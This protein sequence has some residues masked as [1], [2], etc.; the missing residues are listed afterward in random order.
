[1]RG[2]SERTILSQPSWVLTSDCV[3]MAVTHLGAH[4]APVR[5]ACETEQPL[6]PYYISPWQG[7]NFQLEGAWSEV[8]LR[9]DFFCMPFGTDRDSARTERHPSHGETSGALWSLFRAAE[10]CG[11]Q[12]LAIGLTTEARTGKVKRIFSLVDGE[13][14]IY[15]C[16]TIWGFAGPT[17]IAHHAVLRSPE[18]ERG[19]LLSNN[20]IQFA[21]VYPQAFGD[22]A[23]GEY[24]SLEIGAEFRTLERVPSIF[25]HLGKQDC[26]SWPARRGFSD[27]LQIANAVNQ[28]PAWTVAVNTVE[29]YLWFALKD[30]R[31]LPSTII[32]MDNHGRHCLPWQGRNC[33]L[34]LE[35][36]C[37]FFD[38]GISESNR[39]NAFSL[40]GVKTCHEL[41]GQAFEVRY[42]QG[43]VRCPTGFGRVLKVEFQ[44]RQAEFFDASGRKV[45]T[46]VQP[47]FLLGDALQAAG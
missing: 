3:E 26:S 32:W 5:F 34:G 18:V 44:G 11:M 47:G 38:R 41:E 24:Q 43:L 7:E 40:R 25:K 23:A 31:T 42:I 13:N 15:D 46:A 27:L 22:S 10:V 45:S 1:M 2:L 20:G 19:M 14:A 6:Q 36:G 12:T 30:V 9:G 21:M 28:S 16:T 35:D 39:A 37:T 4:M 29:G 33:A 8:P 17:T